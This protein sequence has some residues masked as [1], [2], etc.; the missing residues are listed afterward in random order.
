M[1][2]I[3]LCVAL[4]GLTL[5]GIAPMASGMAATTAYVATIQ[6]A[7]GRFKAVIRDPVSVQKAWG[8]LVSGMDFGIPAGPLARGDG[9]VNA[10]HRW[11][12]TELNFADAT[13]ELCDGTARMVDQDVRYW[14][15]TVGYF[16]PWSGQV[17][18]LEPLR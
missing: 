16:C 5:L 11:H 17:I 15:R 2:R 8:E 14:V 7:D 12:V 4:G 18:A 1:R 6:T 13:I 9:G 3:F 10:P